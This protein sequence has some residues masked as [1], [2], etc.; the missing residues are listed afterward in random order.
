MFKQSNEVFKE[1]D[2]RGIPVSV[3]FCTEVLDELS[4]EN[5]LILAKNKVSSTKDLKNL[6]EA[7]ARTFS[8]WPMTAKGD[9]S[10]SQEALKYHPEASIVADYSRHSSLKRLITT[11]TGLKT[12]AIE[13]NGIVYP[14]HNVKED[15]GRV[16]VSDFNYTNLPKNCRRVVEAPEGFRFVNLDAKRA[17]LYILAYMADDEKLLQALNSDDFH[18]TTAD[19]LGIDRDTAKVISFSMIYGATPRFLSTELG[20]TESKAVV[21]LTDFAVLYPKAW[22][23]IRNTFDIGEEFGKA[24]SGFGT[25][26]HF[27]GSE[28][29]KSAVSHSLQSTAGEIVRLLLPV[30]DKFAKDKGGCLTLTV[31]DSYLVMLP[32]DVPESDIESLVKDIERESEK[33]DFPMYF[34]WKDLGRNWG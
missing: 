2:R 6:A 5:L 10:L 9:F 21:L 28:R 23:F 20:I 24:S 14:S 19:A 17:E 29:G 3:K 25:V 27:D 7:E 22:A 4:K 8:S 11:M 32:D 13:G 16:Y 1:L 12:K 33:Y 30:V 26:R 18:Q 31:F 34:D 15:L